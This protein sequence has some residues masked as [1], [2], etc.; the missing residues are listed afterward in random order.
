[1]HR[2]KPHKFLIPI[3]AMALLVASSVQAN[4]TIERLTELL[5]GAK[6]HRVR[7]QAAYSLA[8]HPSAETQ[9]ALLHAMMDPHEAVRT[10]A[11]S[12]LA[13]V[14]DR[15]A[16]AILRSSEDSN[17]VVRDQLRRTLVYLEERYPDARV[18]I[19]W[20]TIKSVIEIGVLT[21][22]SGSGRR[23]IRDDLRKYFARHLRTK[24]GMAVTDNGSGLAA[25]KSAIKRHR[26][27]PLHMTGNLVSLLKR[28][29]GSDVI[30]EAVVSVTVLDYPG[31][32]IR[33]LL[34]NRAELRRPVRVYRPEQDRV[35]QDRAIEEAIRAA[36]EDLVAQLKNI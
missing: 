23:N 35:M 30:W 14:G 2:Q 22:R 12:S 19:K 26:I 36:T 8:N 6:S 3:L 20:K 7:T 25:L 9:D 34:N 24:E 27:K 31:K 28:R 13:K 29:S 16:I 15:S 1:M 5:L 10:A 4:S 17:H 21:D 18:P 11:L 32:S 33:A